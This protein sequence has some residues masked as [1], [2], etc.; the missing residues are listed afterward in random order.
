MDILPQNMAIPVCLIIHPMNS[1]NPQVLLWYQNCAGTSNF[2]GNCVVCCSCIPYCGLVSSVQ[3]SPVY[4]HHRIGSGVQHPRSLCPRDDCGFP[5]FSWPALCHRQ[6]S[7]LYLCCDCFNSH[8]TKTDEK[9][10]S[11]Q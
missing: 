7:L 1:G 3:V 9:I 11:A 10:F 5:L 8:F 2:S 4:Y 6:S